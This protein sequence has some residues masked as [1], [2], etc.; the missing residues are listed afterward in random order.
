MQPAGPGLTKILGK[1]LR[2]GPIEESAPRA[3]PLVCGDRVAAR[4][5]VL[6]FSNGVLRVEVPDKT[7]RG[8]LQELAPRYVSEFCALLGEHT[9]QRIEFITAR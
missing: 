8:Q 3:W 7:W 4:T 1:V 2:R 5:K 6:D 9:V